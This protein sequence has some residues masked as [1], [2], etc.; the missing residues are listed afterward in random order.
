VTLGFHGFDLRTD[1]RQVF[2]QFLVPH[3]LGRHVNAVGLRVRVG[4]FGP[5]YQLFDLGGLLSI[6]LFSRSV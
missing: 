6:S 1:A 3:Q 2:L 5:V 4:D